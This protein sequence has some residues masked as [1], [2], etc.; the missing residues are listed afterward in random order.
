MAKINKQAEGSAPMGVGRRG[1]FGVRLSSAA[2]K[3]RDTVCRPL[4]GLAF[5][6]RSKRKNPL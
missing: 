2:D 6:I 4:G 5:T 1:R 3:N